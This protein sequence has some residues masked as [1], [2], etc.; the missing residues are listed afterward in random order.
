MRLNV[1]APCLE[2]LLLQISI[3]EHLCEQSAARCFV[4]QTW[5][6]SKFGGH[7]IFWVVVQKEL[8]IIHPSA[9]IL[10]SDLGAWGEFM[11][12]KWLLKW[13][14]NDWL[15]E[16]KPIYFFPA[17]NFHWYQEYQGSSKLYFVKYCLDVILPLKLTS[18]DQFLPSHREI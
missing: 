8:N 14:W 16:P 17:I 11:E 3:V 15:P 4:D 7:F 2:A 12:L 1:K 10:K 9:S 18:F 6:V 13:S 5:K